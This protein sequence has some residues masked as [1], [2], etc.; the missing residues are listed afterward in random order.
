MHLGPQ[1][2]ETNES[3]LVDRILFTN[4]S[5]PPRRYLQ[6]AIKNALGNTIAKKYLV[7]VKQ[8]ETA[9]YHQICETLKAKAEDRLAPSII[10]R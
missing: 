1:A 4:A 8:S 6:S 10:G 5:K 2:E 3:S 9:S 7:E